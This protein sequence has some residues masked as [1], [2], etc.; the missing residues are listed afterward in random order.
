MLRLKYQ[1]KMCATIL[2]VWA[3]GGCILPFSADNDQNA[4]AQN[5]QEALDQIFQFLMGSNGLAPNNPP[6]GQEIQPACALS[7]TSGQLTSIGGA[8]SV[9]Q[10]GCSPSPFSIFASQLGMQENG[11]A[12]QLQPR[13]TEQRKEIP[14]GKSKTPLVGDI[15]IYPRGECK[16]ALMAIPGSPCLSF[17]GP[18]VEDYFSKAVEAF[19]IP[20]QYTDPMR[21]FFAKKTPARKTAA[22][23]YQDPAQN[24]PNGWVATPHPKEL[25]VLSPEQANLRWAPTDNEIVEMLNDVRQPVAAPTPAAT[26]PAMLAHARDLARNLAFK[27]PEQDIRRWVEPIENIV[28]QWLLFKVPIQIAEHLQRLNDPDIKIPP[29]HLPNVDLTQQLSAVGPTLSQVSVSAAVLGQYTSQQLLLFLQNISAWRQNLMVP[30][31]SPNTTQSPTPIAGSPPIQR[32]APVLQPVQQPDTIAEPVKRF[33]WDWLRQS[34]VPASQIAPTVSKIQEP[35]TP[36]VKNDEEALPMVVAPITAPIAPDNTPRDKR[37]TIDVAALRDFIA[38]TVLVSAQPSTQ[39]TFDPSSAVNPT[40]TPTPSSNA[41]P[42]MVQIK[43]Y[44]EPAS[45][46]STF[47]KPMCDY[48]LGG[49][50]LGYTAR[51][52]VQTELGMTWAQARQRDA[53]QNNTVATSAYRARF[54]TLLDQLPCRPTCAQRIL[55]NRYDGGGIPIH[56][57]PESGSPEQ[58]ASVYDATGEKIGQ[59]TSAFNGNRHQVYTDTCRSA[60]GTPYFTCTHK[61]CKVYPHDDVAMTD[62][63]SHCCMTVDG[64]LR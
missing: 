43:P 33:R 24:E 34:L 56:D 40:P 63:C 51:Q 38:R 23:N 31:Q 59:C 32:P 4:S 58:M 21:S 14:Q 62:E 30:T 54:V 61:D 27:V 7:D 15:T 3:L 19:N 53:S 16:G 46:Q 55:W 25:V 9:I 42:S 39:S 35:T 60:G 37:T 13:F 41:L 28:N 18:Q 6:P 22:S 47:S 17:L 44:S 45:I 11:F 8:L 52:Q 29:I 12:Q 26:T 57:S 50:S 36:I 1:A 2:Q 10:A 64:P 20:A 48:R 49:D 5:A